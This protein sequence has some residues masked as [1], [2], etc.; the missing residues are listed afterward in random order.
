M[1]SSNGEE[2]AIMQGNTN[3]NFGIDPVFLFALV[4]WISGSDHISRSEAQT[5]NNDRSKRCKCFFNKI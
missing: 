3:H 1:Y 5:V 2:L 4:R